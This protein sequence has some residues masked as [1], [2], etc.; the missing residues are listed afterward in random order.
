MEFTKHELCL[1]IWI[2][3]VAFMALGNT[4]AI[5]FGTPTFLKSRLYNSKPEELT[6][7]AARLFGVWT[8]LASVVRG[9][10]SLHLRNK[11]IFQVTL[12]T[13]AIAFLHFMTELFA[14]ET[15][16]L[17]IGV[18]SPLII[19]G[20]SMLWMFIAQWLIEFDEILVRPRKSKK[21]SK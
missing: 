6:P 20:I 17:E 11:L 10:C 2:A 15:C 14:Y 4:F 8:L 13:F 21:K 3:L 7:L 12:L 9:Y 5:F 16:L 1:R 18:I 19:S